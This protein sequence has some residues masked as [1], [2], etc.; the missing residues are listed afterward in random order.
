MN[1]DPK[2]P[3]LGAGIFITVCCMVG[4]ILSFIFKKNLLENKVVFIILIIADII[5]YTILEIKQKEDE[6]EV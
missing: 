2:D 4:I 3:K 6:E 1:F 5:V